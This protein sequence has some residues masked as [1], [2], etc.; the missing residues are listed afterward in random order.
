MK[1]G[2]WTHEANLVMCEERA[3]AEKRGFGEEQ[4]A[5]GNNAG[6]SPS[7]AAS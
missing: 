1:R 7:S 2:E 6:D 3:A 4:T 5:E